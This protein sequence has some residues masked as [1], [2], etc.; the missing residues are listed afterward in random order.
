MRRVLFATL[1]VLVG[2]GCLCSGCM[3][4]SS[5]GYKDWQE[6]RG[7]EMADR[8]AKVQP[9]ID[10]LAKYKERHGKYPHRVYDLVDEKLLDA[11]PDLAVNDDHQGKA[12]RIEKARGLEYA[13]T[14]DADAYALRVRFS[15]VQQAWTSQKD[16]VLDYESTTGQWRGVLETSRGLSASTKK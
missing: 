10:A 11:F 8:K 16:Y 6:Y 3:C 13:T 15:F 14:A 2:C 1:T 4:P 5:Y 9:V 7:A 12:G